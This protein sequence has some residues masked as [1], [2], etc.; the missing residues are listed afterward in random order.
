M[1]S[2][3]L[4]HALLFERDYMCKRF[5]CDVISDINRCPL[6]KRIKMNIQNKNAMKLG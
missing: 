2:P 1:W 5:T 3:V 4:F 6:Q